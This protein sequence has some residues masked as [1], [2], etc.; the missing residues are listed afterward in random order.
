ME[1]LHGLHD[2]V[3]YKQFVYSS[4]FADGCFC[5]LLGFGIGLRG[6][7]LN[8]GLACLSSE[9]CCNSAQA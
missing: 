2:P 5:V 6:T 3:S 1:S 8:R 4:P 7:E 9:P